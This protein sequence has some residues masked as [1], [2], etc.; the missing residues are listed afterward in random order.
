MNLPVA[1]TTAMRRPHGESGNHKVRLSQCTTL[2]TTASF[3]I[4]SIGNIKLMAP[5]AGG[6][7]ARIWSIL[8]AEQSIICARTGAT[9]PALPKPNAVIIDV[10]Q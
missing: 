7:F 10:R 4:A 3:R 1:S 2:L 5:D 8:M 6:N 9:C